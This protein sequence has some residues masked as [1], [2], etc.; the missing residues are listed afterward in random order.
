MAIKCNCSQR[1]VIS[2]VIKLGKTLHKFLNGCEHDKFVH[3]NVVIFVRAHQF[4]CTDSI[5]CIRSATKSSTDICIHYTT[6]L[7]FTENMLRY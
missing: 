5:G 1:F 2:I 7:L 3:P 4:G 6:C